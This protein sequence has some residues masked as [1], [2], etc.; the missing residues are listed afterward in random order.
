MMNWLFALDFNSAC[1][2]R[3]TSTEDKGKI[4]CLPSSK[5][6]LLTSSAN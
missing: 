2:Q 3:D 5:P 1:R 6:M 4:L